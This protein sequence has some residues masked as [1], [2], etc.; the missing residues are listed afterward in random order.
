[1][2]WWVAHG[3]LVLA[4][5]LVP[6]PVAHHSGLHVGS[7]LARWGVWQDDA[8]NYAH[9][10][11]QGYTASPAWPAYWPGIPLLIL[12]TRSP[13]VTLAVVEAALLA[14]M[15]LMATVA[16]DLGL[17]ASAALAA[18][19]LFALNPA[20]VYYSSVYPELWVVGGFL[21]AMWATVHRRP[22][23]MAVGIAVATV[24]DPLGA[25]VGLL[26]L[27]VATQAWRRHDARALQ[28]GLAGIAAGAAVA[29]GFCGYL[30]ATVGNPLAMVSAQRYWHGAWTAPG[31]QVFQV[32][33]GAGPGRAAPNEWGALFSV[34]IALSG[35]ALLGARARRLSGGA[36]WLVVIVAAAVALVGLSFSADRLPMLSTGRF[37][38]L[39]APFY[40][41]LSISKRLRI[42]ALVGGGL[43]GFIGAIAFTHGYFWW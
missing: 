43:V 32:I 25:V 1:M 5:I 2:G 41:G 20:A 38:S 30:A 10:A 6:F 31:A 15:R 11:L 40:L 35:V 4:A 17:S 23:P 3:V 33:S 12:L 39:D 24:M 18:V 16:V 29:V 14:V 34:V 27:L 21:L 9:V 7:A 19:A 26:P 8:V 37:V 22:W 13:W 28:V 36:M 42:A